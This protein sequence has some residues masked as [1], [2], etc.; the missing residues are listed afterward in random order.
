MFAYGTDIGTIGWFDEFQND[1]NFKTFTSYHKNK[2]YSIQWCMPGWLDLPVKETTG[3][4]NMFVLSCGGDG[5]ILLSDISRPSAPSSSLN[6]MIKEVNADWI[7]F[8]KV[9]LEKLFI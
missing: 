9:D 1:K 2:V 4:D 8:L 3:R 7:Q 5:Q 6:D